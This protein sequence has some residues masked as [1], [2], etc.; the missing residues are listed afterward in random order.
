M[1]RIMGMLSHEN[2]EILEREFEL[3]PRGLELPTFIYLMKKLYC[4]ENEIS[5]YYFVSDLIKFFQAIDING[6]GHLEWS[7]F[8]EYII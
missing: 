1:E 7:E 3:Y 4:P 5:K 8:T 2:M 6:D